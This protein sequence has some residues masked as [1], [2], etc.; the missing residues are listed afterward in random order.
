MAR[1]SLPA[2]HCRPACQWICPASGPL[3]EAGG[4]HQR[5]ELRPPSG[6]SAVILFLE[7]RA[8]V[9]ALFFMSNTYEA[10]HLPGLL[11]GWYPQGTH[12]PLRRLLHKVH[13]PFR[14]PWPRASPRATKPGRGS[15][16]TVNR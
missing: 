6:P 4:R 2:D 12:P 9:D 13:L 5:H 15:Q 16:R 1:Q 11:P 7:Q 8:G 14:G 3:P 10:Y